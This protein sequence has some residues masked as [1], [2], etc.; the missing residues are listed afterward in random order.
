VKA[1]I[2]PETDEHH[3]AATTDED[4]LDVMEVTFVHFIELF[5]DHH[6]LTWFGKT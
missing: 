1:P 2:V 4:V 3:L 5:S 6:S